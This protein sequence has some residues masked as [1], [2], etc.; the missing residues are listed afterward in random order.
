MPTR[1][2]AKEPLRSVSMVIT[3]PNKFVAEV[4]DRMPVILEAK[5]FE[6]WETGDAKDTAPLRPA[7]EDV[8]QRWPVAKRVSRSLASVE[9]A[10]L[11]DKISLSERA[12]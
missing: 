8:L 2:S 5:D 11:L 6:Q 9:D 3:E 12:S 4:H 7:G 1:S 10:A